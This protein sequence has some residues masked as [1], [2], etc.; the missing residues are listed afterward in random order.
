MLQALAMYERYVTNVFLPTWEIIKQTIRDWVGPEP[1]T[2]YL[3]TNGHILPSC[4]KLSDELQSDTFLYNPIRKQIT[5]ANNRTPEGRFRPLPFIGIYVT[6]TTETI[7]ITEWLGEIR[8]NPIPTDISPQQ[9][10]L[11]W[12]YAKNTYFDLKNCKI[13]TVRTDGTEED[14]YV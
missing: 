11:L 7:D 12:C 5:K 3:L 13:H 8:A 9:I 4:M 10:I 2:Y 1:L 6:K 14:I